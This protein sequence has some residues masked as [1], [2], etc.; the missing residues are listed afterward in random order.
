MSRLILGITILSFLLLWKN[1]WQKT[2]LD[3]ARDHLFDLRD[4][5]RLWFIKEGYGLDNAI[6]L[7]L[8]NMINS[9]LYH[10]ESATIGRVLIFAYIINKHPN[11]NKKVLNELS[12]RF[13]TND[14]KLKI[15]ISSIR[16]NA[17]FIITSQMI[18][19][20]IFLSFI[21][22]FIGF[23]FLLY[24]IIKVVYSKIRNNIIESPFS[25]SAITA[26]LLGVISTLPIVKIG[27]Y[28]MEKYSVVSTPNS[29]TPR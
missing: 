1:V 3:K 18:F 13:K 11:Y 28:T 8:R 7:D 25:K 17:W 24:E 10:L 2:I 4:E 14:R 26:I 29:V 6:Y 20:S 27:P 23:A 15:F 22:V 19:R 21:T 5:L 12:G 16:N 9:Y